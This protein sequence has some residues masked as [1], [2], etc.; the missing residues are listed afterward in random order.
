MCRK[1]HVVNGM[2]TPSGAG[3]RL[4][5][6]A[7]ATTRTGSPES[8]DAQVVA[9]SQVRSHVAQRLQE[10]VMQTLVATT[11]LAESPTTSRQDLVRYLRQAT[12]ELRCVI[13]HVTAS[14]DLPEDHLARAEKPWYTMNA[15]QKTP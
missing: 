11:Y 1:L 7:A 14:E 4:V 6:P 13:D 2:T 5:L 3:K 9:L 15:G 10:S 8:Q 12:H